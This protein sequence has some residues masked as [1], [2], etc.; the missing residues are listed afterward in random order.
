MELLRDLGGERASPPKFAEVVLHSYL[1]DSSTWLQGEC[2][3]YGSVF[4]HF[5]GG[6]PPLLTD[7][8]ILSIWNFSIETLHGNTVFVV[9]LMGDAR[10]VVRRQASGPITPNFAELCCGLGG[11]TCG[12]EVMNKSFKDKGHILMVDINNESVARAAAQAWNLPCMTLDDAYSLVIDGCAMCNLVIIGDI[13]DKR[14]WTIISLLGIQTVLTS[15]PCPPWSNAAR[16]GGLS[17]KDGL[18]FPALIQMS[19]HTGVR[20]IVVEN[21]AS[22]MLHDHY[23]ALREFAKNYGF[24]LVHSTSIDSFPFL[25]IKRN[26]WI[27]AFVRHELIPDNLIMDVVDEYRFPQLKLGPSTMGA[28]DCIHSS[29]SE[30]EKVELQPSALAM[31]KMCCSDFLP[32]SFEKIPGTSVLQTRIQTFD[33]P[34]Q[35]AMATYG[36]QHELDDLLLKDKGMFT[37]LYSGEKDRSQPRYYS[38]FEFLASMAWPSK[39]VLPLDIKQAWK[40]AGNSI[41]IPHVVLALFKSHAVLGKNSP[42]GSKIFNLRDLMSV[43]F[44]ERISLTHF[45]QVLTD[46]RQLEPC[47]DLTTQRGSDNASDA[48][49]LHQSS[50]H[51]LCPSVVE[52]VGSD[53]K[54]VSADD[55]TVVD[56][57]EY[58]RDHVCESSSIGLTS[59]LVVTR[60][61]TPVPVKSRVV[62]K[63]PLWDAVNEYAAGSPGIELADAILDS[64]KILPRASSDPSKSLQSAFDNVSDHKGVSAIKGKRSF[65]DDDTWG[66]DDSR[67]SPPFQSPGEC[68]EPPFD[69]ESWGKAVEKKLFDTGVAKIWP[70]TRM[71]LFVNVMNHWNV[72]MPVDYHLSVLN[73]VKKI[74][75]HAKS[76]HFRSVK[77][78]GQDVCPGSIP[79]GMGR[80]VWAFY[81]V[82][83]QIPVHFPDGMVKQFECDVTTTCEELIHRIH[84]SFS[85]HPFSFKVVCDDFPINR[86]TFVLERIDGKWK[87]IQT[88]MVQLPA[89]A[90]TVYSP[91]D[92]TIPPKHSDVFVPASLCSI[93]FAAR[94]PVWSTV[95]T[96]SV[97]LDATL[98]DATSLL[99]PDLAFRCSVSIAN[100]GEHMPGN[101]KIRC[102]NQFVKHE[103]VFHSTKDFPVTDLEIIEKVSFPDQMKIGDPEAQMQPMVKRWI[104]SP[105]QSKAYEKHFHENASLAMIAGS[106]FAHTESTQALLVLMD[107][108]CV[109]PR[110]LVKDVPEISIITIRACPLLGGAKNADIRKMLHSQLLARGVAEEDLGSRIDA[111]LAKIQPDKLRMH[112]AESGL[113]QW[114]SIKHLA[115]EAKIRLI[116]V[117]ELKKFQ[118]TKKTD[119][120]ETQSSASTAASK[121][122]ASSVKKLIDMSEVKVDLSYFRAGDKAVVPLSAEQFG[123][124]AVGVAV[125]HVDKAERYLPP[126][127]LSS[128]HLAIVAVGGKDIGNSKSRMIPAV[129]CRGEPM[130]VSACLLNFGDEKVVFQTGDVSTKLEGQDAMVI[131]FTVCRNETE[132]WNQVK[133]PLLYLGQNFGEIK[134]ARILF[135]WAVRFF[136]NAKKQTDHSKADY[137]HG[138]FRV[139]VSQVDGIIA[140]SGWAG[141]YMTPKNAAKRPHEAYQIINVPNRSIEEL[142]ALAQKTMHALGIIRTN[143]SMAIRCRREHGN[144]VQRLLFPD[145]P[146][147]EVGQFEAGDLLFTLKHV[148]VFVPASELTKAL[149][150]LGWEGAKAIRPLGA[151]SWSVAARKAPP[152]S[153]LCINGEFAVVI[154]NVKSTTSVAVGSKVPSDAM[155]TSTVTE[156]PV[157]PAAPAGPARIEELKQS[158]QQEIKTLVDERISEQKSEI[159]K[160]KESIKAT[161]EDVKELREDQ[162]KAE[163]R[164]KQEI[165]GTLKSSA[166]NMLNQMSTMFQNLQS[167]LSERL[168]KIESKDA[169]NQE[170]KRQRQS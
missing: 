119:R 95:R 86:K 167:S 31:V 48:A 9:D 7:G 138:F 68:G 87:I 92:F 71:V 23:G 37:T 130:L 78:N 144:Q 103:I 149:G 24:F 163:V 77:V 105:F 55:I 5:V 21:V 146:A 128:D 160:I 139:L 14:V 108:K 121:S 106:Y 13:Q 30:Y 114:S 15:P 145:M 26:R 51:G 22:I 88:I 112:V 168:D 125:M 94:H 109:D 46:F 129:N 74:L 42:W 90:P 98:Q 91:V 80:L 162:A 40:A 63:D 116:T 156:S 45:K 104:K 166:A 57:Q 150:A 2:K 159:E 10:W 65:C 153:H 170:V 28:R 35:S 132:D 131:E 137:V 33:D 81:P 66:L 62:G 64:A 36:S 127:N 93:R 97:S 47:T 115:N 49:M 102:L 118:Q 20:M 142:R 52:S 135:S 72:L 165:E 41:T 11:W 82:V 17:T 84:E 32:R 147:P 151:S 16:K 133:S 39:A 1:S 75:P 126:S 161:G 69:F 157:A 124:D 70:M 6:S 143:S 148:S 73:M 107:G 155:V 100:L 123:P 111:I 44:S 79:A 25:P 85:L 4:V 99:F 18:V 89:E 50:G 136:T 60:H 117:D 56:K 34:L 67:Y 19:E 54:C 158:L 3:S 59:D 101:M 53:A 12:M 120:A 141:V 154:P 83:S 27:A 164:I 76:Q 58:I 29:L 134:N 8:S 122:S 152:A 110:T 113:K 140:K 38:P 169:E 96:V 43:V 61:D